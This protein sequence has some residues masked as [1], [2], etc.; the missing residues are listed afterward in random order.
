[1]IT[2]LFFK[3]R[4]KLVSVNC[5]GIL[6]TQQRVEMLWSSLLFTLH[7]DGTHVT[8]KRNTILEFVLMSFIM[9]R[10]D[11]LQPH[12]LRTEISEH[13]NAMLC[14]MQREF[15]MKDF[16]DI[17]EKLLLICKEVIYG[18]VKLERAPDGY[19]SSPTTFPEGNT[20]KNNSVNR[21][22]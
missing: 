6:N 5:K 2:C 11:V 16:L 12:L 7:S 4:V 15:T 20:A 1:M 10:N 19:T 14:G 22:N 18:G 21:G 13:S 8:T 9:L 3:I 17:I